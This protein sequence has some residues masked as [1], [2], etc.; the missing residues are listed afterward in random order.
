M[1]HSLIVRKAAP[2]EAGIAAH[3]L[4][5][6]VPPEVRRLTI[7]DS[8][9]LAA[10]LTQFIETI[11]VLAK[12]DTVIG[13]I[14]VRCVDN[15]IYPQIM[16]V[17]PSERGN[18][19][20]N[21]L[22]GKALAAFAHEHSDLDEVLWDVA[23]GRDTLESWYARLGGTE[24]GRKGWWL[25]ESTP[26]PS[27]QSSAPYVCRNRQHADCEQDQYGFSTL[28]IQAQAA[29]VPVGKLPG[30]YFRVLNADALADRRF[31]GTLN[32]LDKTRGILH[33]GASEQG[34]DTGGWKRLFVTRQLQFRVD[35]LLL[36][37]AQREGVSHS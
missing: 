10:Y 33:I 31:L 6:G 25:A 22:L 15:K 12:D 35:A 1:K 34:P 3:L 4:Q 2:E 19:Y 21:L 7:W 23:S 26:L 36:A 9:H 30:P 14:C 29:V 37:F 18:G 16:F 28:E 20:G 32:H 5:L 17:E 8:P 27:G 13:A 24:C 11:Y